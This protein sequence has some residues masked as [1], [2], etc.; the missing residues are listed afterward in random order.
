MDAITIDSIHAGDQDA[1]LKTG[2]RK[3]TPLYDIFR[4]TD[5]RR[6]PNLS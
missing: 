6:I 5:S 3:A 2:E 4:I 1:R